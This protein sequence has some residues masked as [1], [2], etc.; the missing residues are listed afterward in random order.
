MGEGKLQII[1]AGAGRTGTASL[2]KALEILGYGPCY[3]MRSVFQ[4]NDE[5]K[6]IKALSGNPTREDWDSILRDF[7]STVD[8]PGAVAYKELLEAY[9]DAKVVLSVRDAAGWVRSVNDTIWNPR[10]GELSPM[11]SIWRADFQAM[12]RLVR[13]RF[14]N[15][16]KGGFPRFFG[17]RPSDESLAEVFEAWNKRVVESLP[18]DK[19]LVFNVKEG[20]EPLCKFL[21]KPVPNEPFPHVN[22][23]DAFKKQMDMRWRQCAKKNLM[24]LGGVVGGVLT[25]TGGVLLAKRI[26]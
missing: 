10:A 25:L 24:L 20:W 19:L 13:K 3:H 15:D 1:G 2:Q 16:G 26:K 7:G 18:K 4:R 23:T 21:G 11:Q 17:K 14:F 8:Y 5:K 12:A 6:W 9:P 22:D